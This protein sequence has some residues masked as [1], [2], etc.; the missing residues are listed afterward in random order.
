M[1]RKFY[2]FLLLLL[3]L[4]NLAVANR[5]ICGEPPPARFR[6]E[7]N[8]SIK[9]ELEGKANFL[10]SFVGKAELGGKIESTR[11]EIFAKY[12]DANAANIDRYLAYMFCVVIFD[13]KNKQDTNDKIKAI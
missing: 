7:N 9:G 12:S 10:S 4:P 11:K 3:G 13:P 8:E 1:R 5:E 6:E 2:W